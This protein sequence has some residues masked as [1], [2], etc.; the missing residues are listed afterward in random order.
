MLESPG[1]AGRPWDFRPEP[2]SPVRVARHREPSGTGPSHL[3]EV[4]ESA[5]PRTLARYPRDRW[6]IPGAFRPKREWPG[7]AVQ[8][9]GT[10]PGR[11]GQLVNTEGL[12]TRDQFARDGWSTT[13]DLGLGP[14]PQDRW[15]TPGALRPMHETPGTA[16]RTPGP[17][18][19]SRVPQ[20]SWSTP[21]ALGHGPKSPGKA[22]RPHG[23]S[24]P[25]L[26]HQ[27][28]FVEP[29][30]PRT[31]TRVARDSW[32]TPG[33]L[34]PGPQSPRAAGR[35]RGQLDVGPSRLGHLV[36]TVVTGTWAG[37]ARD[38]WSTPSQKAFVSWCITTES[39]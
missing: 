1:T 11:P 8:H 27:G 39:Y 23:P 24:D 28:Q 31:R 26:S 25:V 12:R 36:D 13:R 5:S 37:V 18:A 3:G 14:R 38:S 30:G 19:Q 10:V 16:V 34:G 9:S 33:A 2:E 15:S 22:G 35:P 7:T 21:W 17:W 20:D 32:M 6:S 29:A 4:V